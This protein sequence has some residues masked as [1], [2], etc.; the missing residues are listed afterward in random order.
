HGCNRPITVVAPKGTLVNA[1]KPAACFQRMVVAHSLVDLIMGALAPVAPGKVMAD[2]AGCQYDYCNA[3]NE[4]GQRIMWGEVT[5]GG[6]GARLGQDGLNV[7]AC[8]V[9]NCPAPSIEALEIKS[10]V[11]Y[12]QRESW[13][14]SGGPGKWRGGLSQILGYKILG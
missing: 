1:V 5:A 11:L 3:L 12:L 9:T 13:Q 7:M 14:D 8:H 10:P 4:E 2:S 6:L